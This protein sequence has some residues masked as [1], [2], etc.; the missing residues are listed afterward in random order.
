LVSFR[1]LSDRF[2]TV[3]VLCQVNEFRNGHAISL[4]V[5]SAL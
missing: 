4:N 1:K 2:A 3:G 5:Y